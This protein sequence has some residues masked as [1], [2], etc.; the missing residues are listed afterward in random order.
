MGMNRILSP[1]SPGVRGQIEMQ[2][3]SLKTVMLSDGIENFI[4]QSFKIKTL[5][6]ILLRLG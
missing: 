2:K 3:I 5:L 4:N 6:I 1:D